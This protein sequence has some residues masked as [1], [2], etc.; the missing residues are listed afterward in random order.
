MFKTTDLCDTFEAELQV[1]EPLLRDFG[2][3]ASFYG[4]ISTLLVA[5]D[6]LLVR[7]ALEEQG[8][9][10]V[11]VVDGGALRRSAL[12]GDQ[13]AALAAGNGW[14]GIVINGCVRDSAELA[15]ITIGIKALAAVPRRSAK[16]GLGQRDIVVRFAGVIFTPGDYLYADADGIV[17]ATRAL[18]E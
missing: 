14:A 10:R 12:V 8:R 17:L 6:N 7:R 18:P 1:A 9:G 3:V 13:L 4:P 5:D 16:F 15:H 11:L 2:G